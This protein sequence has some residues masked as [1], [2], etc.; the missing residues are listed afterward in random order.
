MVT[1]F[2]GGI[3]TGLVGAE[4]YPAVKVNVILRYTAVLLRKTQYA[5]ESVLQLTEYIVN[6]VTPEFRI[7]K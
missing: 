7:L 5:F 2:A 3:T 6:P 1:E 4:V